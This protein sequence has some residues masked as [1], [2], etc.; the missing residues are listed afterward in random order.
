MD[1][2]TEFLTKPL[3]IAFEELGMKGSNLNI[4]SIKDRPL[5]SAERRGNFTTPFSHPG[6][7]NVSTFCGIQLRSFK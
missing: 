7:L 2:R 6:F 3:M 5:A 4:K 1:P